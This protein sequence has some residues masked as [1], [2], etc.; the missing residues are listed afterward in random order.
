[1]ARSYKKTPIFGNAKCSSEKQDK[2][3]ANR[4]LR[5]RVKEIL[6]SLEQSDFP[7]PLPRLREV[8]DAWDFG[9]DGKSYRDWWEAKWLRK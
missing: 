1:M 7:A 9:K 5:R 3:R 8:S 2:R 6:T 4:T